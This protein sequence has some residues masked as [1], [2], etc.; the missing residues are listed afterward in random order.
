M[1]K[2]SYFS[3]YAMVALGAWLGFANPWLQ[4]PILVLGFPAGL[5]Q[6]ARVSG[7]KRQ[8]LRHGLQASFLAF[9]GCLYWVALPIH[10]FGP[11]PWF[12]AVPAAVLLAFYMALY[13]ALFTLF[14]RP[15]V[16]RRLGWFSL[17]MTGGLLW[18]VFEML[19]GTILSGFPWLPLSVA[20]VP[21]PWFI[22]AAS[23][24]GGWGLT[25][26]FTAAALWL[27]IPGR[28]VSLPRVAGLVVLVLIAGHGLAD[29]RFLEREGPVARV[30]VIQGNID[31][32][33]KWE[34]IYQETTVDKYIRLSKEQV[35]NHDPDLVVW[36]ETAVPFY[37][38]EL[39]LLSSKVRTFARSNQVR[40][41]TGSPAYKLNFEGD[42]YKYF[43]RAFLLNNDGTTEGVYDKVH[44]VPFGE[45]IPFRGLLPINTLV[46]NFGDFTAGD[47]AKP[48]AAGDM[49]LGVLI[50]YEAIFPDLS[51]EQVA[52]GANL[53]VNISNDAWFS[54]SS[55]PWQH[56]HL[57]AMRAVEQGRW[58]VRSTNT[59]IST[60]VTPK[61]E[62]VNPTPLFQETAFTREVELIDRR[63]VFHFL[64]F[65]MCLGLPI[66]AFIAFVRGLFQNREDD[67]EA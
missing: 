27:F 32:S 42:T 53:L 48:I 51:Q 15:L 49:S 17:G 30:S 62:I 57:S 28:V 13:P 12:V 55:A 36:P 10:D 56:L 45:Y 8:A 22:Q 67:P 31:Q 1:N 3:G 59:G 11:L 43:N 46:T 21:W 14:M 47:A 5:A 39:N 26:L 24:V 23:L 2:S 20:F 40:L 50:C 60:L 38:Q 9:M 29:M 58:L 16:H 35:E 54:R 34:S 41:L 18:V 44:L 66:F 64:Y 65:P 4:I 52:S 37:F 6:I 19:Q 7:S 33:L 63:T 61:G 25:V